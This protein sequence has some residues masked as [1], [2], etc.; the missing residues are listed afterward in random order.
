MA[1]E[2][3]EDGMSRKKGGKEIRE[4][5]RGK[6]RGRGKGENEEVRTMKKGGKN[7]DKW[8]ERQKRINNSGRRR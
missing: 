4:I 6:R 7:E 2:G 1:R 3:R 8:R 5:N